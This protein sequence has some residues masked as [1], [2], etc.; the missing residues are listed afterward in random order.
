[1]LLVDTLTDENDGVGVGSG[2]SL[3]DAVAVMNAR[4]YTAKP[5]VGF[6]QA[7]NG[8]T[9]Q[10]DA[11]F[12]EI[13]FSAGQEVNANTLRRGIR[14]SGPRALGGSSFR[15]FQ[16]NAPDETIRL[17]RLTVENGSL[18]NADGGGLLVANKSLCV[19]SHCTVRDCVSGQFG[20]GAAIQ[21]ASSLVLER[22]TV[23]GNHAGGRGGGIGVNG[24]TLVATN[25][26]ISGN[27]AEGGGGGISDDSRADIHL[28]HVTVTNNTATVGGGW[29]DLAHQSARVHHTILAGNTPLNF[30]DR[31]PGGA[32]DITSLGYNLDD[33]TNGEFGQLSDQA[34]VLDAVLSPLQ[35][36]G[37][38]TWT[39][40]LGPGSPALNAGDPFLFT[41]DGPFAG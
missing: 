10:L 29:I 18:P 40:A 25:T 38:P 5:V 21:G 14:I 24:S 7:L 32:G 36:N 22:S 20:A 6:A 31:D 2:T 41:P 3:R 16:V 15:V 8:G 30:H 13:L 35:D 1:M 12:G 19:L 33:G 23:S 26:T 9:I 27:H 28:E 34:N 17:K 11:A 39:H 37:G 4:N